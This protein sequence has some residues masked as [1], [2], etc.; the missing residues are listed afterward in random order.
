M[1]SSTQ[2]LGAAIA[3][4]SIPLLSSGL[5]HPLASRTQRWSAVGTSFMVGWVLASIAMMIDCRNPQVPRNIAALLC[6]AYDAARPGALIGAAPYTILVAIIAAAVCGL[7]EW[8]LKRLVVT[9]PLRQETSIKEKAMQVAW[10]RYTG[11]LV[12]LLLA[13]INIGSVIWI[14]YFLTITGT[15]N[16]PRFELILSTESTGQ[17]QMIHF[18]NSSIQWS[19]ACAIIITIRMVILP[20]IHAIT[21]F[22]TVIVSRGYAAF[23]VVLAANIWMLDICP[24]LPIPSIWLAPKGPPEAAGD[25][26]AVPLS[27]FKAYTQVMP[28]NTDR[29]M[30]GAMLQSDYY[31]SYRDATY[32]DLLRKG[33]NI[34]PAIKAYTQAYT[35]HRDGGAMQHQTDYLMQ[36][37]ATDKTRSTSYMNRGLPAYTGAVGQ[38]IPNATLHLSDF[39]IRYTKNAAAGD[40]GTSTHT[41]LTTSGIGAGTPMPQISTRNYQIGYGASQVAKSKALVS[42]LPNKS[43]FQLLTNAVRTVHFEKPVT[44]SELVAT[45]VSAA[46]SA[47]SAT[48]RKAK[49]TD[50][51]KST[52]VSVSQNRS[53]R[54]PPSSV[55]RNDASSGI[56]SQSGLAGQKVRP[57]YKGD[58]LAYSQISGFTAASAVPQTKL[59]ELY[60]DL[61][62]SVSRR[63]PSFEPTKDWKKPSKAANP[64]SGHTG[65]DQNSRG[66][67]DGRRGSAAT[68][69][70]GSKG[71]SRGLSTTLE[72][73]A[74]PISSRR[75]GRNR[76]P[77]EHSESYNSDE[78]SANRHI[79]A[80]S[81]SRAN[82]RHAPSSA[83]RHASSHKG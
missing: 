11:I 58:L 16:D 18:P 1:Y 27:P 47:D 74:A 60:E 3:L 10:W 43:Q 30:K 12:W 45:S 6:D 46:R 20:I 55:S 70:S 72:I 54:H 49:V 75:K 57:K 26:L 71:M 65:K 42:V 29:L 62:T 53:G 63:V 14:F 48:S 51:K 31:V 83:S 69:N 76:Q 61:D 81:E 32:V 4:R 67:G 28:C 41:K 79:R 56:S 36:Y 78:D 34:Q 35:L 37:A 21:W 23:D 15:L 66:P 64:I 50:A 80:A 24:D 82:T 9:S 44:L 38:S 17:G 7:V 19:I 68:Q 33:E 73:E 13:A 5:Y 77:R 39:H 25:M 22:T 40:R 52:R 8:I 59:A 2:R